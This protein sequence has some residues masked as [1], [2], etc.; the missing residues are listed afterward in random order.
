MQAAKL[1]S[2]N[3][4]VLTLKLRRMQEKQG[5]RVILQG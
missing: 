5:C 3:Y 1:G 2:I 4:V